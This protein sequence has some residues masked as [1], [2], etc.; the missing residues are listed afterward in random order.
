MDACGCLVHYS[1]LEGHMPISL[2]LSLASSTCC[3]STIT[4]WKNQTFVRV[5]LLARQSKMI[6]TV[7][8]VIGNLH[9]YNLYKYI[10]SGPGHVL[11]WFPP[12]WGE[13]VVAF[14]EF[15]L[16]A[17]PEKMVSLDG[18]PPIKWCNK[19]G[20][21]VGT[22]VGFRVKLVVVFGWKV[23]IELGRRFPRFL[24]DLRTSPIRF[25]VPMRRTV[26]GNVRS[27]W[28]SVA[29]VMWVVARSSLNDFGWFCM[30][31]RF[32]WPPKNT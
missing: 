7:K 5:W 13:K 17:R 27:L 16:E 29:A 12:S 14:G 23:Q 8:F 26:K 11:A 32:E 9:T 22:D 28:D 15:G 30:L 24:L 4:F 25:L 1:S 2:D 10:I 3:D 6:Q 18:F 19:A 20:N 31:G 21:L